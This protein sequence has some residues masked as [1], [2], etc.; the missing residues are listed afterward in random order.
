MLVGLLTQEQH[1]Q[2]EGQYL[3]PSWEYYPVLD[4]NEPQN[5]V[6]STIEMENT[7]NPDFLWV[8]DLPLI[9]WIEPPL[10]PEPTPEQ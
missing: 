1:L 9:E 10:P 7:T 8:K 2:I 6:I 4:G 3:Q 5:W